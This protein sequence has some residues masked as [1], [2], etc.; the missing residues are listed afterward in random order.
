MPHQ[1]T[2]TKEV[3]QTNPSFIARFALIGKHKPAGPR[4]RVD[5]I[6]YCPSLHPSLARRHVQDQVDHSGAVAPFVVIP[7]NQLHKVLI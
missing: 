3:L 4:K 7:S 2:C 5:V 6:K 1:T